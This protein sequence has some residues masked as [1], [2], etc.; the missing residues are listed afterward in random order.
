MTT[1]IDYITKHPLFKERSFA[2][3]SKSVIDVCN[4]IPFSERWEKETPPF[5]TAILR[6]FEHKE[7]IILDYGTGVGR[8]AKEIIKQNETV[9]VVGVDDS[10]VQLTHA[11]NYVDSPRFS[12][13]LPTQ[14]T[15]HVDLVFCVYVLQ[16][17]PAVSLREAITRMHYW[18]RPGGKLVLC[19][20]FARMAPRYDKHLTF[21]DDRMLGV[22][23]RA[24]VER[25]FE[26]VGDLFT[27]EE[28]AKNEIVR[29][30][31]EGDDGRPV[32]KPD[33]RFGL[34]H[35]AI[36]YTRREINTVY[37]DVSFPEWYIEGDM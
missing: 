34:E 27:A 25:L 20:A 23:I 10:L 24:E 14:L 1:D 17:I 28:L 36:V 16:H 3:A 13:V 7:G 30:M 4:N 18:L 11:K 15:K 33:K 35:P 29:R 5:A 26:P 22:N 12:A 19:T 21:F 31:V 8:L 6:H 37:F 2:E 9:E 32:P